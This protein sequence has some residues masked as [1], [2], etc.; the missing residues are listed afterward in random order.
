MDEN[1]KRKRVK[2]STGLIDNPKNRRYVETKIMPDLEKNTYLGVFTATKNTPTFRYLAEEYLADISLKSLR[3]YTIKAYASMLKNHIY[4]DFGDKAIDRITSDD[5]HKWL[6]VKLAK[7]S[8]KTVKDLKIPFSQTFEKAVRQQLIPNNPFASIPSNIFKNKNI[9]A[10]KKTKEEIENEA[11][12]DPFNEEEIK[13]I[14][15]AADGKLKNWI[16]ISFF[17]ALRPSEL[18]FLE[19]E[20]VHLDKRYLIVQGAITGQQ[21]KEEELLTKTVS[22]K[23]MVY[24]SDE[25]IKYFKQQFH[26]TG[27]RKGKVFLNKDNKPY[28]SAQSIRDC[29]WRKLF[30]LAKKQTYKYKLGVRYRSM[31]NL[32]HSWASINLSQSRLPLVFISKQMG[33]RDPS[34]TL[35]AYSTFVSSSEDEVFTML[36]KSAAPFKTTQQYIWNV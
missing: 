34:I 28:K 33:H 19:W 5:V 24:L 22:S 10:G 3:K 9:A 36:N 1:G 25:A 21:T 31:Y 4:D 30:D 15:N 35:K 14:L 11:K 17:C 13:H 7:F 2:R 18:L 20:D 27:A 32:R 12:I 6:L 29:L 8:S 26:L 23:R 16:A